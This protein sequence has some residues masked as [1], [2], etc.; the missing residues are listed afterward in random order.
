MKRSVLLTIDD[1]RVDK[2][3]LKLR[4]P[5]YIHTDGRVLDYEHRWVNVPVPL[6]DQ[7]TRALDRVTSELLLEPRGG[8]PGMERDAEIIR[9]ALG[10]DEESEA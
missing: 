8:F 3:T 10:M 4:W 7:L 9:A 2:A 5:S 6:D 1:E